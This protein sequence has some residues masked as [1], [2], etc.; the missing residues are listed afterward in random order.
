MDIS[1]ILQ[2]LPRKQG[3]ILQILSDGGKYS[4]SDLAVLTRF[5]DPRGHIK[6]LRDK[7]VPIADEWKN[8]KEGDGHYKVYFLAPE[9]ST[10]ENKNERRIER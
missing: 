6:A 8:N 5:A 3:R 9:A 4:V 2:D 1:S 10:S 7:G